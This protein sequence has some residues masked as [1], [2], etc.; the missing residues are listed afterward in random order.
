MLTEHKSLVFAQNI[1][2]VYSLERSQN[3]KT[4]L[5]SNFN[6]LKPLKS[7]RRVNVLT[8]GNNT[9]FKTTIK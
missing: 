4:I 2:C 3:K 9:V 8:F 6:F 1:D 5:Y 7:H